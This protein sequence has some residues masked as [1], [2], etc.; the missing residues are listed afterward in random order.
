MDEP[1]RPRRRASANARTIAFGLTA[2]IVGVTVYMLIAGSN[3]DDFA[4]TNDSVA[5]LDAA[6]DAL[7]SIADSVDSQ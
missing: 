5:P 6:A 4:N 7:Q 1:H 2:V 3:G